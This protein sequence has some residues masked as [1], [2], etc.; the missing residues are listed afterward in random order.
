MESDMAKTVMG[1]I[2]NKAEAVKTVEELLAAGIDKKDVGV[3][4]PEEIAR[5]TGA[6]IA[7]ASTG[8]LVGGLAGML[9]A[10][11]TLML[12]GVGPVLVAGPGATLL[13]TA[14][15]AAAGGLIGGLVKRG[16]PEKD[17]QFLADGIKR[18]A[19]LITVTARSD[20]MAAKA[21][22]IMKR[23]GAVDLEQRTREWKTKGLTGR[24]ADAAMTSPATASAGA[25]SKETAGSVSTTPAPAAT[26]SAPSAAPE[27]TASATSIA[28]PVASVAVYEFEIVEPAARTAY[29]GAERR[30][31][32]VPHEPER[33][34]AA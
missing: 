7:G 18:G 9:L 14:L 12:P 20:D 2:D 26:S 23:H 34:I 24:M 32:S 5:E 21:V 15:G 27:A 4:S 10:A 33:R 25:A 8:M 13:G 3:I 31:K 29:T 16:V 17:A 6:A 28:L 19:T 1:L 22:E 11:A 30:V